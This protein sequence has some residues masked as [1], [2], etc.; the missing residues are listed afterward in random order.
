M[1]PIRKTVFSVGAL[2]EQIV[3]RDPDRDGYAEQ[4]TKQILQP[5][6]RQEAPRSSMI[7]SF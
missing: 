3:P 6:P 4:Q 2:P 5:K 1:K 7:T